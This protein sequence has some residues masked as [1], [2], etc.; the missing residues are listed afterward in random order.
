MNRSLSCKEKRV[1]GKSIGAAVI[2]S[3]FC[4]LPAF[5]QYDVPYVPTDY[6]VVDSMLSVA[7]VNS[8]DIMYDL[9]CGDGRIVISA[10]K[11]CNVRKA[12][13][14]DID[15]FRIRDSNAN[16]KK[17]GV[18]GRVEFREENIFEADY[19][20]AT[21]ITMYLLDTI[22]L[23]LRQPFFDTLKPGTRLVS[24]NFSMGDWEPDRRIKVTGLDGWTGHQVLFW[25]LPANMSGDWTFTV[26]NVSHAL[27]IDQKYQVITGWVEVNGARRNITNAKVTGYAIQFS[28]PRDTGNALYQYQGTLSGDTI[29]GTILSGQASSP[30][31]TARDPKTM[32]KITTDPPVVEDQMSDF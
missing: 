20:D 23:R 30:W 7:G 4:A 26:G 15:P 32:Q 14:I 29:N 10:V 12:V 5:A 27:H 22:N 18:A 31:T 21:V 13:G 28:V 9:G 6:A 3:L 11:K 16:A 17:E 1:S 8:S 19:S 25:V 2:L 24:H